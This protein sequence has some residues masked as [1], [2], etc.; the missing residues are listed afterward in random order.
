MLLAEAGVPYDWVFEMD[1]INPDMDNV[2]VCLVVSEERDSAGGDYSVSAGSNSGIPRLYRFDCSS[3]FRN[4]SATLYCN[5]ECVRHL[6]VVRSPRSVLVFR[7]GPTTSRTRRRATRPAARST[8]CPSLRSRSAG[9][10]P[11][12]PGP[13]RIELAREPFAF[14]AVAWL[15]LHM[16]PL[17]TLRTAY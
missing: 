10:Q 7:W 15:L 3:A 17:Y 11:W 16:M 5:F 12:T 6:Q 8:A 4:V 2:D 14:V 1:E 9:P 13:S